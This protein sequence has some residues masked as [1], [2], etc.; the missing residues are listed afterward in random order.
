MYEIE[1]AVPPASEQ[2]AIVNWIDAA[3]VVATRAIARMEQEVALLRDY[4]SRLITDVATGK[5]DVRHAAAHLPDEPTTLDDGV[6]AGE[7]EESDAS[8][9]DG[10]EEEATT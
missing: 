6:L 10:E 5:L 4:R 7:A 9:L 8:E 1:V 2:D 3:T